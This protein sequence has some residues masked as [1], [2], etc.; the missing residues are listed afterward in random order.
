M[1]FFFFLAVEQACNKQLLGGVE[2]IN[3]ANVFLFCG[4]GCRPLSMVLYHAAAGGP[5]F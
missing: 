1:I 3:K 2:T 4:F 5:A